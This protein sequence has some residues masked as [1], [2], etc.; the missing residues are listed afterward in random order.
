MTLRT[1]S[2]LP[3]A[4]ARRSPSSKAKLHYRSAPPQ[5]RGPNGFLLT[6]HLGNTNM[7]IMTVVGFAIS[8]AALELALV[9][10][11]PAL[12]DY[13]KNNIVLGMLASI[14]L[15]WLLGKAFGAT[16]TM[17][18]MA[19]VL[20]TIITGLVYWLDRLVTK[21]MAMLGKTNKE[22]E[23]SNDQ[24]INTTAIGCSPA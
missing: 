16:G 24:I 10:G 18:V 19:A 4:A 7:L 15:S 11:C 13:I 22:A 8:C 1:S 14:A 3:S 2:K 23:A 20:S 12:G 9:Y 6:Y 17:V 21:V 5:K